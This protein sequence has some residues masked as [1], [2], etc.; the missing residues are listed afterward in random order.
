MDL[1]SQYD[2]NNN[3]MLQ[4]AKDGE[5]LFIIRAQDEF[6]LILVEHWCQMQKAVAHNTG[7]D[8]PEAKIE[9]ARRNLGAI[10]EWQMQHGTKI[11]D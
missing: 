11:P 8:T 5:P 1:L 2:R 10:R 7:T 6:A 4:S 3:P 9:S